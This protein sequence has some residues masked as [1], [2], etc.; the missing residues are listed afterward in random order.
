MNHF[1]GH[2]GLPHPGSFP[3]R[4]A[5]GPAASSGSRGQW[6]PWTASKSRKNTMSATRRLCRSSTGFPAWSAPPD[7]ATTGSRPCTSTPQ[8][9]PWR[10][11]GSP[12]GAAP[13]EP[14]PAGISSSPRER[15]R[16]RRSGRLAKPPGPQR[17]GGVPCRRRGFGG[18]LPGFAG[19]GL[20]CSSR[21][22]PLPDANPGPMARPPGPGFQGPPSPA[23]A[24][25]GSPSPAG[26][27]S[28]AAA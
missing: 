7:L 13:E 2:P 28:G 3:G 5:P 19:P 15:T 16:G 22:P 21:R 26:A 11:G 6:I 18:C 4:C 25:P 8:P 27:F 24:A 20:A 17:Q 12:C 1:Q 23:G 10:R 14:I 9:W